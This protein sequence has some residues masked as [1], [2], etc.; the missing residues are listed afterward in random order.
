MSHSDR[1]A[2]ALARSRVATL[3]KTRLQDVDHDS[4]PIQGADAISLATRLTIESWSLADLEIP[5]YRR[6]DT[7]YRFVPSRRT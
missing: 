5:G 4:S 3:R 6:A 1:E 2:R 7:P